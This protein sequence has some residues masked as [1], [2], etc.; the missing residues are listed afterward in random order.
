MYEWVSVKEKIDKVYKE[1][2]FV[3]TSNLKS[4]PNSKPNL[5]S[6]ARRRALTSL[7]LEDRVVIES[8]VESIKERCYG[9]RI[10]DMAALQILEHL[11]IFLSEVQK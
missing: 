8:C 11:G 3:P 6:E 5:E 2:R 4:D 9:V 1:A 7:E 10:G